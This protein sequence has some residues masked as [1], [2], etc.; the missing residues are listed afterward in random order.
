MAKLPSPSSPSHW[1]TG[2]GGRSPAAAL[3]R[4]LRALGRPGSWG[5]RG[6]G[7]WGIDPPTHLGPGRSEEAGRRGPAAAARAGGG[8]ATGAGRRR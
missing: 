7:M 2:E 4:W 8:G 3:G 6:G 5:K 1:E